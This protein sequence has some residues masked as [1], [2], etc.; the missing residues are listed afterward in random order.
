M[1]L[2]HPPRGVDE[3]ERTTLSVKPPLSIHRLSTLT[4]FEGFDRPLNIQV[5]HASNKG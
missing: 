5:L 2:L 3:F 1:Y 4:I